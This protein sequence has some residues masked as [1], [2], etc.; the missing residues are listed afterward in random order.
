MKKKNLRDFTADFKARV[1]LEAA[2]K[3]SKIVPL[4]RG[5]ADRVEF[6]H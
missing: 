2:R 1:A 5:G 6:A 4:F 3:R